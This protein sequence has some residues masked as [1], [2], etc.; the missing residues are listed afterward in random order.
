V[1]AAH[2]RAPSEPLRACFPLVYLGAEVGRLQVAPRSGESELDSEDRRLLTD[3]SRQV[4]VAAHVV[5]LTEDLRRS[6]EQ[7]VS[8]REEERR[9]LRRDLH[10]GLGPMHASQ[11]LSIDTAE[12][13]MGRDPAEAAALLREVKAQTQSAIAEIRRV[14]YGLRPPAL[15]DL[16]LAGALRELA[17]RLVGATIEVRVEAPRQ[18]APLP[19]AAEVAAYRIAQEA[20]AN[21]AHHSG[22]R[23]CTLTLA[24]SDKLTLTVSD[25]GVGI[26]TGRTAG[27]GLFSMR[28]RAEELGGS[29][30]V[31]T[32]SGTGTT[33]YA[34]LPLDH[35]RGDWGDGHGAG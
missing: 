20:L 17:S 16:G 1:A 12:L 31:S 19:A 14:V 4:G 32:G 11:A 18:L 26:P 30:E 15:D 22:A 6:R 5:R 35:G 24:I 3:L 25:D 28:E 8:A 13:L 29:L 2:G 21:V 33:V 23:H 27:V 7:L 10:D 34:T 9:R